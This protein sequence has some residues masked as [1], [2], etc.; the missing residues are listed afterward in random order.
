MDCRHASGARAKYINFVKKCC[1]SERYGEI[2]FVISDDSEEIFGSLLKDYNR[3]AKKIKIPNS[4]IVKFIIVSFFSLRNKVFSDLVPSPAIFL[5]NVYWIIHDIRPAYGFKGAFLIKKIYKFSLRACK[6][7]ITVSEFSRKEIGKFSKNG[8]VVLW[9]NGID[10]TPPGDCEEFKKQI[11]G[12]KTGT[13]LVVLAVGISDKR[14]NADLILEAIQSGHIDNGVEFSLLIAGSPPR[15]TDQAG[16]F[17][18]DKN[19][20]VSYLG[21]VSDDELKVA[22]G[23][24]DVSVHVSSYEGFGITA[25]EG[26][27]WGHALI[28]SDIP[29]HRELGI[30]GAIW[31][32]AGNV[33]D[34]KEALV[35]VAISPDRSL[36]AQIEKDRDISWDDANSEFLLEL[37]KLGFIG[38]SDGND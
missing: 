28:L 11:D 6:K 36:T 1:A 25:L 38:Q 34:L 16:S 30:K 2:G 22:Y 26:A 18:W 12:A 32:E 5:R 24:A 20:L 13:G 10:V 14:K 19:S 4:R 23:I 8:A 21:E 33:A 7:Y 37:S 9:K 3:E 27:Y 31:V 17:E 15:G 29:A 35:D